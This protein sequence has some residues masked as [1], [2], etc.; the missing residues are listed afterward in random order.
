[1]NST[2]SIIIRREHPGTKEASLLIAELD[3]YLAPLYPMESQ[4]GYSIEKLVEQQVEFF[5][6]YHSGEPAACGGVQ[7]FEDPQ[8]PAECYG[9]LKRMY[10]RSQFRGLGLAKQMLA[11]LERVAASMGA[12]QDAPGDRHISAR[13]HRPLRKMRLLPNPSVRQLPA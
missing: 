1:M 7:L 6:L 2:K 8:D 13:G 3:A 11:H 5:V 9:E 4:H 10:V 12:R